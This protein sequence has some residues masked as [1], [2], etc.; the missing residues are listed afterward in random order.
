MA[1]AEACGEFGELGEGASDQNLQVFFARDSRGYE[2]CMQAR[3]LPG[4]VPKELPDGASEC[5]DPP[6][7]GTNGA[8][9][10]DAPS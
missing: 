2:V 4:A 7:G 1:A 9:D 8:F 10:A 3:I 5:D 6:D